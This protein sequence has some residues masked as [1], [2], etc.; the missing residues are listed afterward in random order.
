[1]L[2]L[3]PR[4]AHVT[5]RLHRA[6]EALLDRVLEALRGRGAELGHLGD[7]HRD[8]FSVREAGQGL[9]T[10]RA[11]ILRRAGGACGNSRRAATEPARFLDESVVPFALLPPC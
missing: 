6:C 7:G 4:A 8:S 10:I 2:F 3:D 9:P 5:Q 11:V 1:M